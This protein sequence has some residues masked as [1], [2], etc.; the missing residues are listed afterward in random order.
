[1]KNKKILVLPVLAILSILGLFFYF[2]HKPPKINGLILLSENTGD[3]SGYYKW[4]KILD[5]KNLK[6]IIKPESFVLE[7]YPDYFRQ[8]ADKGYEIAT[9][10][11]Q[12]PFWDMPYDQQYQIMKDYKQ[13]AEAIIGKP[14]R[15]FSSKYFAYD[16]NTLKA[17]DALGIPYILARGQGIKAVIYSP[18]EYKAKLLSVS[19]LV[20]E[21]MGSGSLCDASLYQRGS[22]ADEFVQVLNQTFDENPKDLILVSHVYIGG[23]RI[24]WWDAYESA[25]NS[26]KVN[27]RDFDIWSQKTENLSMPYAQIPYNTEVKYIE[28]KPAV[29]VEEIELIPELKPQALTVFHNGQGPMC[30]EFLEFIKKIDY[31]IEQYLDSQSNFYQTLENYKAKFN[32]SQGLSTDF[33]YY[34]I[35]FIKDKAFSGFNQD[36]KQAILN[37]ISAN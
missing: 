23:T 2:K 22:T 14:I 16:E 5:E 8:L 7:K 28:P 15:I 34:P 18:H 13:S 20:F 17:A 6:A 36:I 11:G 25:L 26:P 35:I 27:W 12:A 30:L 32:K 37:E 10:Y 29:P 21:D 4:E 31:P 33:G 19:N 1:M 9:G 24:G 3:I